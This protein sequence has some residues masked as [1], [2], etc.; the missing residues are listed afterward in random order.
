VLRQQR[1]QFDGLRGKL[2]QLGVFAELAA[3]AVE[4]EGA[5]TENARLEC[6]RHNRRD[7]KGF[8]GS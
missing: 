2:D 5:K 7:Y 1:Q 4:L 8:V 6:L 3:P